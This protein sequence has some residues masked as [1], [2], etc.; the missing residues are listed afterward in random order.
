MKLIIRKTNTS[1]CCWNLVNI[2]IDYFYSGAGIYFG[3][4]L[5]T[6]QKV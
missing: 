1:L 4:I 6:L 3:G 5:R 2:L